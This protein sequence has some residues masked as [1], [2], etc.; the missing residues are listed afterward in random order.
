LAFLPAFRK[1]SRIE[2]NKHRL[3]T[4]TKNLAF[5]YVYAIRF[6]IWF[7]RQLQ[8]F[9]KFDHVVSLALHFFLKELGLISHSASLLLD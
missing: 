8:P 6:D 2:N 3:N 4:R 9:I 7:V 1:P 5:F